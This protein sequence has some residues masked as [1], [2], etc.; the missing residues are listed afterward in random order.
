M[1]LINNWNYVKIV[2]VK[3][4]WEI[5]FDVYENKEHRDNGNTEFQKNYQE[6][7]NVD[8]I[9]LFAEKA[10]WD[11]TIYENIIIKWYEALKWAE[12]FELS[13]DII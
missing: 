8:L 2:D 1:A 9:P 6:T 13:K 10:N 12:W 11:I 5:T 7:K 3:F 4:N